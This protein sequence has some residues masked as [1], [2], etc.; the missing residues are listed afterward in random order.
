MR[1]RKCDRDLGAALAL[2]LSLFVVMGC[3]TTP[4]RISEDREI[5]A[6][7]TAK[8]LSQNIVLLDA[9]PAFEVA[10]RPIPQAHP[11]EWRDFKDALFVHIRERESGARAAVASGAGAAADHDPAAESPSRDSESGSSAVLVQD[12][13]FHA[14]RLARMGISPETEVVV[15]GMGARGGGDEGRLAWIL[16]Y[17]GISKVWFAD[18]DEYR[19]TPQTN[20]ASERPAAPFWKP[21]Y[22]SDLLVV[23]RDL[24]AK[25]AQYNLVILSDSRSALIENKKLKESFKNRTLK[26]SWSDLA[27]RGAAERNAELK[28]KLQ[29][30]QAPSA[31]NS[32]VVVGDGGANGGVKA[33]TL[34]LW[35]REA[36]FPSAC[37]C[38][39]AVQ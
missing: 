32:W 29:T 9:R 5:R 14:R 38:G 17:M 28:Q 1:C 33:A 23:K 18:V 2:V 30:A 24:K 27:K 7:E 3:Q 22:K 12:F 6:K 4:T 26:L 36:G 15:L 10:A 11:L 8:L 21:D 31:T 13:F 34:T 16:Q 20:P 35:L 19:F 37:L 39:E 25:P